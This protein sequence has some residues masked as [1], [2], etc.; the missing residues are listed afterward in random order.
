MVADGL[1]A[2]LT[3]WLTSLGTVELVLLTIAVVTTAILLLQTLLAF[4]DVGVATFDEATG[5][6]VGGYLNLRNAIVTIV[7]FSWSVLASLDAGLGVLPTTAIGVAVGGVFFA[8]AV[9]VM[10][11][12]ARLEHTGSL[13]PEALV[14]RPGVVTVAV[15]APGDSSRHHGKVM[16]STATGRQVEMDARLTTGERL[17]RG[18]PVVVTQ[19]VGSQVIVAPTPPQ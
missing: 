12:F 19:V 15:P 10:R 1:A 18:T 6:G 17:G 8:S 2:W 14:D 16:I 11:G 5:E 3:A 4:F 7:G 9:V 13:G